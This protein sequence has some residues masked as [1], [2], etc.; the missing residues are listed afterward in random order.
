MNNNQ[1]DE[2]KPKLTKEQKEKLKKYAVFFLMAVICAGCMWLIFAPSADEKAK[3]EAQAGF[4]ADIPMP[5]EEGLIDNKKDAYEQGD[6]KQKQNERMRSLEDFTALLGDDTQKPADDLA[7]LDEEPQAQKTSGG[8]YTS[9]RQPQ[10]SIQSSAQAYQD[11]NRTLGNFYETPKT[12]PEK[13][14]LSKELEELKARLDEN[15]AKRNL[16]D[17]QMALMEKS[18]QMASKYMPMTAGTATVPSEPATGN[19]NTTGKSM[20]L[21]VGQVNVR[22]VSTLR[23]DISNADFIE[24]FSRPRNMG[25]HT[26]MGEMLN[27][28]KNTISACIHD[29]QTIL[30]GQSVRLRLLEAMQAGGTLVPRNT[31]ITGQ[32]KIQGERL[33]ITI[34]S[35]EY[36]GLIIPVELR[37]FD[38]D[39]QQ[40][41]FIPGSM[42][43]NAAKEIV[44][45][46]G[47]NAGTSINLTS[48]AGEQ[49]AADMGRNLI[50]GVTQFASK[51]LREVKV[52]LKA[53]YRI[54]LL[55][56][57]K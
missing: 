22:T 14:R 7:L 32:S 4:N 6:M 41:I 33:G 39:G 12:D 55:P 43:M 51:K 11:I 48:D 26:A 36:Q 37:V 23:Q 25:F 5:K 8:G 18:F 2:S 49:F 30:D 17:E 50:Q 9:N 34:I 1:T 52:N 20:V 15:E 13:E 40:G 24:A 56:N 31:I 27:N 53:G 45:N 10:S 28:T 47:T 54:L 29:D 19:G 38:T 3:Q 57:D 16:K 21:P 35:L 44:S 46:M 42:E